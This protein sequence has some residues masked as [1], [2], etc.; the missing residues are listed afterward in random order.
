MNAEK[1]TKGQAVVDAATASVGTGLSAA[2]GVI[3][4]GALVIVELL[5]VASNLGVV[6]GGNC[7]WNKKFWFQP[8][9][10]KV[11]A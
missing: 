7:L 5:G 10:V 4:A 6:V 1:M 2:A 11:K 9:P 3:V 8:E